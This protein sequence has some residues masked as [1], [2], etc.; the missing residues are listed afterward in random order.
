MMA[1][2]NTTNKFKRKQ[3]IG[4]IHELSIKPHPWYIKNNF[5]LKTITIKIVAT[6]MKKQATHRNENI[7]Y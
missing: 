4:V 5:K 3:H 1:V 2:H 6:Q 7:I